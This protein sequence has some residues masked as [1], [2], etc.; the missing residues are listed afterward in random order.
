MAPDPTPPTEAERLRDNLLAIVATKEHLT[1]DGIVEFHGR[2]VAP[3]AAA[4]DALL[5]AVRAARD[6]EYRAAM[7]FGEAAGEWSPEFAGKLLKEVENIAE[8]EARAEERER[9]AKEVEAL[10]DPYPTDVFPEVTS[11]QWAQVR[12]AMTP[13]GFSLDRVSASNMRFARRAAIREVAAALR[14]SQEGEG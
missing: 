8:S 1:V 12:E 4:L 3:V 11:E 5:A 6:A 2:L 13:L 7:G 10:P 9:C 14:A